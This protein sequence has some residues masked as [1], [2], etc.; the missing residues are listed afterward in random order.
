M[1]ERFIPIDASTLG[2]GSSFPSTGT[3]SRFV[4]VSSG[5]SPVSGAPSAPGD[6]NPLAGIS[7]G[8][9]AISKLTGALRGLE[10][11]GVAPGE[12]GNLSGLAGFDLGPWL[13]GIGGALGVLTGG[14]G[15]ASG[16]ESGNAGQSALGGIGMLGGMTGLAGTGALGSG[17]AGLASAAAPVLGSL[18]L[19]LAA[20]AMVVSNT[21]AKDAQKVNAMARDTAKIRKDMAVAFPQ[22]LGGGQAYASLPDI[23]TLPPD[24]QIAALSKA[25]E[26]ARLGVGGFPAVSQY[27]ATEG[28]RHTDFNGFSVA[29]QDIS[30]IN[31]QFFPLLGKSQLA[32][33]ASE[34]RLA[35]LGVDPGT[36]LEGGYPAVQQLNWL[37]HLDPALG[38]SEGLGF[39]PPGQGAADWNAFDGNPGG[40]FSNGLPNREVPQELIDAMGVPG[41][42]RLNLLA[43]YFAGLDPNFGSSQL[44]QMFTSLSPY[45]DLTTPTDTQTAIQ[46]R[47]AASTASGNAERAAAAQNQLMQDQYQA[48]MGQ[49]LMGGG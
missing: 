34:D 12:T 35:S 37:W 15:L 7:G 19:P 16:I 9:G 46:Q 6:S 47:M 14:L 18:A 3:G 10:G 2:Q 27:L 13:G 31:P 28:G 33:T 22:M 45:M 32:Q 38:G 5:G 40:Y 25:L 8:L 41:T 24:E 4:P 17:A 44:G 42:N 30:Q 49:F 26:A 11:L 1:A 23:A 20:G 29:P 21:A 39:A 48:Q 36:I 43:N